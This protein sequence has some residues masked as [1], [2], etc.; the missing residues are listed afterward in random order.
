MKIDL[1]LF[2]IMINFHYHY[3]VNH[4]W[5]LNFVLGCCI[6]GFTK[7]DILDYSNSRQ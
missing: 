5:L 1:L 3:F 2:K 7:F 4:S 6:S